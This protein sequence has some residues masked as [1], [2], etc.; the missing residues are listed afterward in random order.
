M[1]KFRREE[2]DRKLDR[3]MRREETDLDV[4]KPHF[5]LFAF[6][7]LLLA[8]IIINHLGMCLFIAILVFVLKHKYSGN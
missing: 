4:S 8:P 6:A 2:Y 5:L 3:M 7:F 1:L